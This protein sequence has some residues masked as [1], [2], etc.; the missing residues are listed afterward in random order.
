MR[1]FIL[2][3]WP[4]LGYALFYAIACNPTAAQIVPDST[5]PVNSIVTP[6]DN[7]SLIEG[8]TR[9]G[10][11]LFHSFREFSIPTGGTAYFNNALDI[12]NIFSRVTGSSISNI[13]G[14]IQANGVANLFLLNP[15][16]IIF[17]PNARL[18]IGGSFLASTAT[19]VNFGNGSFFKA[20]ADQNQ[21]LLTVSVPVGLQ[22]GLN[23]GRIVVQ[24][25]GEGIRINSDLI[26]TTVGL[27]V[28]SDRTLALVGGDI[29]IEGGTLKTAGGRIELGSV[30]G[31][32]IVSLTAI[33]KGYALGYDNVS[34]FG[35]I[36]LSQQGTADASGAGGGDI[37]VR[38]RRV[39]LKDGSPIQ[40]NTLGAEAGGTLNVTAQE[41]VELIG[42]SANGES[43]SGLFAQVNPGAT[44]AGGNLNVETKRLI[45]LEGAARID[46]S[47]FGQ[48]SS[49][50]V[51]V[52]ASEL[53]EAS[54][55]VK[56]GDDIYSTGIFNSS[57]E[58]TSGNVGDVFIETGR[59]IVR[60]GA[61]IQA[62]TF[63]DSV[64][65]NM[66]VTATESVDVSGVVPGTFSGIFVETSGA[67]TGG[68]L[69][70][71]TPQLTVQDGAVVSASSF[72]SSSGAAG[73]LTINTERLIVRGEGNT[74]ITAATEGE[75]RGGNLTVIASELVEVSGYNTLNTSTF[76]SGDAGNLS[77][78]TGRLIVRDGALVQAATRGAGKGG[79]LTV[80]ARESVELSGTSA[81]GNHRSAL[82]TITNGIGNAGEL[83]VETDR[84]IITDRAGLSV[85]SLS[86][87]AAGNMIVE[88]RSMLLSNGTLQAETAAGDRGNIEMRSRS[89]QLRRGSSITTN[90]SNSATGGNIDITTDTL[91]ALEDS[92]ISA[93]AEQSF[94]GQVRINASGIF[95]TS[96]RPSPILDTPESDITATSQRGVE[97]SGSVELNT[98]D[99][100][101]SS[102]LVDLPE[103]VVDTAGLIDRRCSNSGRQNRFVI[104]GRGGLPPSISESLSNDAIQIEW[105]TLNPKLENNFNSNVSRN[106]TLREPSLIVEAQGWVINEK[107]QVILTATAPVTPNSSW[108]FSASCNVP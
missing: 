95:G 4:I 99:V 53:L 39:I 87:G 76:G 77:I 45:I 5:L 84:L 33:D 102:G 65:G 88:A 74:Q 51:R 63:G 35:D 92:D 105:V 94:G 106:L 58:E 17:G 67:G 103:E 37:Q 15:N 86:L 82:N 40:A 89:I 22:Y 12:H 100:D 91:A 23:P 13:D 54:G 97:F 49:G 72:G 25:H 66:T 28:Q 90:A 68:N 42:I 59:L 1:P 93:N 96:F 21:P 79:T 32:G 10:G 108:Q 2:K 80:R 7:T 46:T 27:R 48:G 20:A 104:S 6:S 16:G 75:G 30:G 38:A 70:I 50:T 9:A 14:L 34:T 78:E 18:N 36:Q 55:A 64:A 107:G 69:T 60:D 62:V 8:G 41:S 56:L 101:P 31:S 73:N 83:R 44:G 98:P 85:N 81:D 29:A 19:Q 47:T 43:V 26:D 52:I 71:T 61:Q 24:G 11:N 3:L 57:Q